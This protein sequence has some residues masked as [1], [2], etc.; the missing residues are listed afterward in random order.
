[1]PSSEIL[2]T[3][4]LLL[5]YQ[6]PA[7]ILPLIALWGV[8]RV[9]NDP[10]S[11]PVAVPGLLRLALEVAYFGFAVW[12]LHNANLPALAWTLAAVLMAHYALSY[13]R[14]LWLLAQRA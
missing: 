7:D 1:M 10:G 13:D 12:A 11:A 8:F 6:T 2:R 5:R 4:R 3:P 9:P 14:V